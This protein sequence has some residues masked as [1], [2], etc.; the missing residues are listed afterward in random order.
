MTWRNSPWRW[1]AVVGGLLL[2]VAAALAM[3]L[4]DVSATAKPWGL[5]ERL[6]NFVVDRS[7]ARRAPRGPNPVQ[8]SPEVLA[9]GLAEYRHHCLVC[10]GAPGL[11]P[12]GI[13][14]GLNPEAPDLALA[15]TQE[16]SDGELFQVISAGVRMSGM[17]AFSK[18]ESSETLW[19]LVAFLR[20][21]P[22]L[23]DAERAALEEAPRP[24]AEAKPEAP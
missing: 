4:Y 19:K 10:H 17:P 16:A 8:P 2:L 15:D 13:A 7:V 18:S 21:L 11:R 14:K 23:S 24:R 9:R 1:L 6:A 3:G 22:N 20:H 5:E 12:S